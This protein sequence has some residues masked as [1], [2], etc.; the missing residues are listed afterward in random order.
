MNTQSNLPPDVLEAIHA[1]R[2]IEAIKLLREY[3]HLGLKEAKEIVDEYTTR[4]PGMIVKRR[5][6]TETGAGRV[7]L[8]VILLAVL[9]G[10]YRLTS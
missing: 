1:N 4:N 3:R 2:K 10:I 6:T 7:I 8:T 9:Y 5:S